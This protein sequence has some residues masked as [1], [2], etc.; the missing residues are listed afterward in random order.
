MIFPGGHEIARALFEEGLLPED[1]SNAKL[2][3]PV[4]GIMQ[5]RYTVNVQEKDLPKLAR[6]FAK[7]LTSSPSEVSSPGSNHVRAME[8]D[9]CARELEEQLRRQGSDINREW[10]TDRIHDWRALA[11]HFRNG[12]LR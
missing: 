3:F 7:L 1:A 5:L 8:R 9:S 6:A 4:D 10:V 2:F 12:T 11:D